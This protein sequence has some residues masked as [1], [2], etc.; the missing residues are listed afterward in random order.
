M[1]I[2]GLM[3]IVVWAIVFFVV[4][5][6]SADQGGGNAQPRQAPLTRK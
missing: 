1:E 5:F 6:S 2:F 4:I 3:F